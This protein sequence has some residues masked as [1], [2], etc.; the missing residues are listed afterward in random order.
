MFPLAWW[1]NCPNLSTKLFRDGS[2][3]QIS[4][5]LEVLSAG[6]EIASINDRMEI[7]EKNISM[8]SISFFFVINV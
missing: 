6:Q 8:G 5:R 3:T 7:D 2:R 1:N 4:C